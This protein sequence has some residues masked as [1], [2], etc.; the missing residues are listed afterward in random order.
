MLLFGVSLK[1]LLK[2]DA[3]PPQHRCQLSHT[4]LLPRRARW[5]SLGPFPMGCSHF[6]KET[7][8]MGT[9]LLAVGS[10]SEHDGRLDHKGGYHSIQIFVSSA[11]SRVRRFS[12][13]YGCYY[14]CGPWFLRNCSEF[15]SLFSS[16]SLHSI[17]F[18]G[19]A[20]LSPLE[21]PRSLF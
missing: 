2:R 10:R 19:P 11:C 3:L 1:R 18:P 9:A 5:P 14:V 6:L 20:L 12:V 4:E 13:Q 16:D 21:H 8:S 15:P 7:G 17:A